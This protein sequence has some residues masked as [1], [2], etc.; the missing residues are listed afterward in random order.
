MWGTP[1]V[2][3]EV[4]I[5]PGQYTPL[6]RRKQQKVAAKFK[7]HIEK[8]CARYHVPVEAAMALIGTESG[9]NVD[10]IS[11]AGAI[12]L[13]QLMPETAKEIGVDPWEPKENLRG[14][15]KYLGKQYRRF[16]TWYL[17]FAAYNAGPGRVARL[18]RTPK[19]EET[20]AYIW[21]ALRMMR[22]REYW[23]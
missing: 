3:D 14:G 1:I 20:Q 13:T 4:I 9:W 16:K 19:I 8:L 23:R 7:P 6:S 11:P 12:G 15:I 18:G 21:V 2:L 22:E 17:A 5:T 10:A